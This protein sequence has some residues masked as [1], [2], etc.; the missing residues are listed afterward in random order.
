MF[1]AE[2]EPLM[3]TLD[4]LNPGYANLLLK[5]LS[6]AEI[7]RASNLTLIGDPQ[8]LI[9]ENSE[10]IEGSRTISVVSAT[11]RL[12][13]LRWAHSVDSCSI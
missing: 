1:L 7:A 5:S 6:F 2:K 13:I 10:F 8:S 4:R 9:C 3:D 12:A 11:D